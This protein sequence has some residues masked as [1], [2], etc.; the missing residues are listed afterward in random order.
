VLTATSSIWVTIS[1][2]A[3]TDRPLSTHQLHTQYCLVLLK[4]F[5]FGLVS[6]S[7]ITLSRVL[8]TA[9]LFLQSLSI[10]KAY[11]SLY[12]PGQ[13]QRFPRG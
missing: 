8:D 11:L 3:L 1:S 10:P 6:L 4:L 5:P 7:L 9:S 13:T 12:K 2:I